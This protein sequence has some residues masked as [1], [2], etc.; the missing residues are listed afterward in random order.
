[1][2]K[3]P[4]A[5]IHQPFDVELEQAVLG[6]CLR[7]NAQIDI[8]AADLL[9]Q[10]GAVD[11][12]TNKPVDEQWLTEKQNFLNNTRTAKQMQTDQSEYL[13]DKKAYPSNRS[14]KDW[15]DQSRG[16]AYLRGAIFPAQN[17]EWNDYLTDEQKQH[18]ARLLQ[19]LQ[20]K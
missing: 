17:P 7:D 10:L 4:E 13:A 3:T 18:G 15:F 12:R 20:G 1:M 14:F 9:H 6:C 16:D 8:A 2:A 19:M 11:P 5:Y